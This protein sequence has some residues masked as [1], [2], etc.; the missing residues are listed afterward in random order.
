M[1]KKWLSSDL[2]AFKDNKRARHNKTQSLKYKN[3]NLNILKNS[4]AIGAKALASLVSIKKE[5]SP[6]VSYPRTVLERTI[7]K[8]NPHVSYS[9]PKESYALSERI[10]KIVL[11]K[12]QHSERM[13]A[14]EKLLQKID[15][16]PKKFSVENKLRPAMRKR[17]EWDANAELSKTSPYSNKGFY[18]TNSPP[19]TAAFT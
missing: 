13:A 6:R 11:E 18:H 17:Q 7:M 14:F 3:I 2:K 1:R 9:E 12:R 8:L 15:I 19:K 4:S 10:R 5:R 16:T